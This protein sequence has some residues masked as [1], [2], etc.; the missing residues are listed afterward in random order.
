[1]R[2]IGTV[3][4]DLDGVIYLGNELI[5]GADRALEQLRSSGWQTLFCTN[6]SSRT[7]EQAAEKLRRLTRLPIEP[8]E[9]VSSAQAA[10]SVV[11][12]QVGCAYVLG[13][14]GVHG[15]LEAVGVAVVTDWREAEAVVVGLDIDLTYDVL[16]DASLADRA[17]ARFVATNLDPAFPTPTGVWPGA[18][19]LVAAVAAASGQEPVAAGKP[20]SPMIELLRSRIDT[21][22]PVLVI[23]DRPSTDLAMGK[24]AG[25]LTAGVLTGVVADESE[26]PDSLAPDVLLPSIAGLPM[27]LGDHL[28][29]EMV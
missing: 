5:P 3:V 24:A 22:G 9:T 12:G 2:A 16:R 7:P 17:G 18:G 10:A 27:W 26:I 25:W 11:A 23:G 15:A 21:D 29:R 14:P 19:A 13:G 6:N 1:M 8:D 20:F 28:E 4:C